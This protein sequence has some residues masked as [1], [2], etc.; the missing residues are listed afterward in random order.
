MACHLLSYFQLA[1]VLQVSGNPGRAEAMSADLGAQTR[2]AGPGAGS[3]CARSPGARECD[4]SVGHGAAF[5]ADIGAEEGPLRESHR[6]HSAR[7]DW[8]NRALSGRIRGGGMKA[9]QWKC[10]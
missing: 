7:T 10:Q 9:T 4:P 1:A 3:S 2:S 5:S 8:F 6:E